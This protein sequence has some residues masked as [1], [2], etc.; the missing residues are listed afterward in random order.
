MSNCKMGTKVLCLLVGVAVGAGL[1]L[2]LAPRSGREVRR[3]LA[4]RAEDGRDYLA[5]VS[6]EFRR[7]AEDVV[8]RGKS[9]AARLA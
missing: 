3:Y 1:A 4:R 2:L 6:K 5:A 7:Q 8:E 9:L